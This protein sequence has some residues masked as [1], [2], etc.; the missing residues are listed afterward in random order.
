MNAIDVETNYEKVCVSADEWIERRKFTR[1]EKEQILK[2]TKGVCACCGKKLTL[3]TMTVEHIIPIYRHGTNDM[4]NLTALCEQCNKDKSNLLYLPR[5]FYMAMKDTQKIN[6]MDEMVREWIK[7][8]RETM[9]IERF[10]LIAP[11]HNFFINPTGRRGVNPLAYNRQLVYTWTLVGGEDFE[12]VE[13]VTGVNLKVTR[14]FLKRPRRGMADSDILTHPSY[15]VYKPVTFY[16]LRKLSSQKIL[17]VA[18]VRYDKDKGDLAISIPWMDVTKRAV[19]VIVANLLDI[20]RDV[21]KNLCGEALNSTIVF[22]ESAEMFKT[23][24]YL[25]KFVPWGSRFSYVDSLFYEDTTNGSTIYGAIF[26]EQD[27]KMIAEDFIEVPRWLKPIKDP[28]SKNSYIFSSVC[29]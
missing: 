25:R 20:S 29:S 6:E 4:K 27:M 2:S 23:L 8:H 14:D 17:A 22:S 10:P 3:K 9:D 19:P 24:D 15:E 12:E 21:I 18:G 13:A 7:N 1:E 11:K 26:R 16:T 5:S 28:D